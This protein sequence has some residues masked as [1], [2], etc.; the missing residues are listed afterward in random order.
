MQCNTKLQEG[1]TVRANRA[2]SF[3]QGLPMQNQMPALCILAL[4]QFYVIE[5]NQS[6]YH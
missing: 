3:L 6:L 1:Y 4:A 5:W 2:Q